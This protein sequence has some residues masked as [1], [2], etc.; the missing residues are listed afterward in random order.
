MKLEKNVRELKQKAKM[1]LNSK[2][3]EVDTITSEEIDEVNGLL[4]K[5]GE[6][7]QLFDDEN[8]QVTEEIAVNR[9]EKISTIN[10]KLRDVQ[11]SK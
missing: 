8:L 5:T 7:D 4:N 9:D 11:I 1:L 6:Q 10:K 3:K 2:R